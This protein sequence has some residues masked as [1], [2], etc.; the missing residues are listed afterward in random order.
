MPLLGTLDSSWDFCPAIVKRFP[1]MRTVHCQLPEA[2]TL[3]VVESSVEVYRLSHYR[4]GLYRPIPTHDTSPN[5]NQLYVLLMRSQVAKR[6]NYRVA[7]W[8]GFRKILGIR[9]SQPTYRDL[10][11]NDLARIEEMRLIYVV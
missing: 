7:L 11:P 10:S 3:G 8:L 9:Q 6:Y 2:I 1:A 5:A 4:L